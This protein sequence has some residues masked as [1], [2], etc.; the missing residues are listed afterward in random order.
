MAWHHRIRNVFSP[1]RHAREIAREMEFHLAERRDEL[2]AGGMAPEEAAREAERRFG[3]RWLQADRTRDVD[4]VVWLELFAADVRYAARGLRRNPG[5]TA[6]A[7]LSLALGI[8]ANTAI[9][10]LTNA[11]L[12]RNLPVREPEALVKVI[13]G[14]HGSDAFTN[15]LWEAIRDRQHLF[16]EAF[17]YADQR[18]N[19]A[20]SGP[21]RHVRGALVSGGFFP[22]LGVRP[23]AGRL[24]VPAD[25]V[26]GCPPTAVVSESFAT[27]ELGGASAALGRTVSLDRHAFTVVGV[28]DAAFPGIQVGA[29]VD[30]YVPLCSLTLLRDD[31]TVLDRR[32]MWYLQVIGR[33]APGQTIAAAR[34]EL[35]SLAP[36]AFA[37]TV[38]GNWSADDQKEYL[39]L[40]LGAEPAANGLS[41]LRERYGRALA[42]LLGIVFLVLLVACANIANLMLARAAARQGESALRRAL[43]AG[44]V[45]LVR[46]LLIESLLLSL[47]G[48]I[49]GLLF[50]RWASALLVRFVTTR[51]VVTSLDLA[52]DGRILGFTLL[53]AVLTGLLFALAP[54]RFAA[55]VAPAATARGGARG[56]ADGSA[57]H[58]TGKA[59][60]VGQV[61]LSLVLV[62]AAALLVGS[63]RRLATVDPGFRAPGVLVIEADLSS[64]GRD[65]AGFELAKGELLAR[66]RGLPEVDSASVALLTPVG[67]MTWNEELIV[68]GYTPAQPR[69]ALAN[70]NAVRDGYF[71]TLGTPLVAGRDVA[72]SDT[73]GA[74][75]V[76][77]V[78][79]AFARKYLAG[80]SPLGRTFRTRVGE[81]ASDPV[82]VV[83][84]VGD[85][86][87]AAL[88]EEPPPTVYRPSAQVQDFGAD[89]CF[90]VRSG[91]ASA[92]LV[93]AVKSA[94]AQW[95][96][97]ISYELT[98]LS[99]QLSSALARPRLLATLSG[100]FG[101]LALLLAVIGLYGTLSYGVT[102]RRGEIGV[103]M[104]LGAA[105]RQV[106]RMILAEAGRLVVVGIALGTLLTLAATRWIASFLYGA[107]ATDP[108]SLGGAAAILALAALAAALLPA[109]RATRVQP[110]Q[111][112][113]E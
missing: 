88:D 20:D 51:D 4:V 87:Y 7:I 16:A 106:F 35:A 104:A 62:A 36:A 32:S 95:N 1:A 86:K 2:V 72:A 78:N 97:A 9:F 11:L 61:A 66:L 49:S 57:H 100:F 105:S 10:S 79:Q 71:A 3:N 101:A 14:T 112:L 23:E 82:E 13:L 28:A 83:G 12:L 43:G 80:G 24:L 30:L 34:A 52:F 54:A 46:Q 89:A 76:A 22:A 55:G 31:P 113:R 44:R 94:I 60:V 109:V 29:P 42:I 47:V 25:D 19:L 65:A 27:R 75:A 92:A 99:D 5:F 93:P 17:A 63:F 21:V 91:V 48:A 102:R 64:A 8:G 53:V 38:P 98:T 56:L 110:S 50:A 18:F 77:V 70:F 39:A 40:A 111:I 68:P 108:A 59:L 26:R 37:A 81:G 45:R 90:V 74:P 58:R 6:V 107:G 85:A 69:E 96:P 15:P 84:L 67:R 103:R 41:E 73:A 33:L